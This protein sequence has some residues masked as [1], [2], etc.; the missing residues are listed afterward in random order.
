MLAIAQFRTGIRANHQRLRLSQRLVGG[1]TVVDMHAAFIRNHIRAL[2]ARNQ[3]GIQAFLIR[4]AI[5]FNRTIFISVQ[6]VQNLSGRV[7]GVPTHPRT[8]RMRRNAMRD[9]VE[10][11]RAI[12]AA[13]NTAIG[14]L[15]DNR[16]IAGNP[17]R[18]RLDHLA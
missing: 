16:K 15:P 14:R 18:M 13:F 1:K 9:H 8:R 3:R 11:H 4:Q 5:H 7:D 17:I 6:P 2:A 12:A 10:T